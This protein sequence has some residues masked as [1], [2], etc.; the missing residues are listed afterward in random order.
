MTLIVDASVAMKWFVE[1]PGSPYAEQVLQ[2]GDLIA[3][4]LIVAEVANAFWKR[5][6]R[7]VSS[8]EQASDAMEWL[9][10]ALSALEPMQ[11]LGAD[12]IRLAV[13]HNH[14]VDDCLYLALARREDAPLV[15]AD[16]KLAALA[17][18]AGIAVE[19]VGVT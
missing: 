12:A 14:P 10:T 18:S 2:R 7:G 19:T 17:K 13:A 5:I 1:E 6:G 16:E 9:P 11:P 3:P 15:T 4:S 8:I